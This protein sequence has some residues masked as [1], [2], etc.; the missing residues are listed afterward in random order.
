[1]QEGLPFYYWTLNERYVIE[2]DSFDD[3]QHTGVEHNYHHEDVQRLHHI[4]LNH[5]EDSSIFAAWRAF[6]PV[7]HRQHVRERLYRP[8]V[9]LPPVPQAQLDMLSN[10]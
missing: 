9:G 8:D 3:A 5:R 1:M 2:Q 4:R 10:I 6:L 7:R